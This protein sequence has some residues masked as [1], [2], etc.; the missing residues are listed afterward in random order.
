[1]PRLLALLALLAPLFVSGCGT[2]E[3]P[4]TDNSKDADLYA[5][6]VKQIAYSTVAR[7]NAASTA[8]SPAALARA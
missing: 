6:D 3:R 2:T 4:F 1:M 5:T 7:G 8:A